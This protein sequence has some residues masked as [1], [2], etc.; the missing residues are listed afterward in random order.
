MVLGL[1]N[2]TAEN[3]TYIDP[4][5]KMEVRALLREAGRLK[6]ERLYF[7]ADT[8][9]FYARL[10]AEVHEQVTDDSCIMSLETDARPT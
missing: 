3:R 5:C 6:I 1:S 7:G 4:V 8:P 9:G 10:G 2:R